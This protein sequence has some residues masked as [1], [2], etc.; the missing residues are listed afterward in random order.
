LFEFAEDGALK[1]VAVKVGNHLSGWAT[2][3]AK[4]AFLNLICQE[5]MTNVNCTSA[6]GGALLAVVQ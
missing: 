1:E 3:N 5:K 4:L 6:L 2:G